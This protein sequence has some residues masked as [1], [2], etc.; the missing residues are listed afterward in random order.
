[1]NF[2]FAKFHDCLLLIFGEFDASLD[3]LFQ[4][5]QLVLRWREG[6]RGWEIK[7]CS[8]VRG[9]GEGN[10]RIRKGIVVLLQKAVNII[11]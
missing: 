3:A 7:G 9:G 4:S 6:E 1:M 11:L 2:D 10:K 8:E 5:R